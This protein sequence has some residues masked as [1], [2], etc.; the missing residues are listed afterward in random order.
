M[1]VE[2]ET[3]FK[4]THTHTHNCTHSITLT[5]TFTYL[6]YPVVV[7][8]TLAPHVSLPLVM[9]AADVMVDESPASLRSCCPISR[10]A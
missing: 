4:K 3:Y 1:G 7:V 5:H 8:M 10:A 6:P 9:A 2:P